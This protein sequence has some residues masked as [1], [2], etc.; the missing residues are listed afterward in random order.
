MFP[1]MLF[2]T[3]SAIMPSQ[4]W[5]Q[6]KKTKKQNQNKNKYKDWISTTSS[7]TLKCSELEK[8]LLAVV[9][10]AKTSFSSILE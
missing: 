10:S 6:Q 1:L 8:T 7:K 9:H 3:G 2:V 4:N 5:T